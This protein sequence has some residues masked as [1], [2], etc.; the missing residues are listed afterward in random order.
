MPASNPTSDPPRANR[1]SNAI[2]KGYG[3]DITTS[4]IK[5]EAEYMRVTKSHRAQRCPMKMAYIR[6]ILKQTR[7]QEGKLP[8]K[9]S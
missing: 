3:R 8:A 2:S 6:A 5:M 7:M 1:T 4:D 9:P